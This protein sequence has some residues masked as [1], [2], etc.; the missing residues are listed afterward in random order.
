MKTL[1]ISLLLLPTSAFA[2][3]WDYMITSEAGTFYY[4]DPASITKKDNVITY[5]Q[6]LNYPKGYDSKNPD[7]HSIQHTKQIDCNNNTSRTISMLAYEKENLKGDILSLSVGR[8]TKWEEINKN[9][10]LSLYRNEV[11]Q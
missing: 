1:F 8:E 5:I 11:C 9:S 7:I 2:Q 6:L 3:I 10:I 4:I